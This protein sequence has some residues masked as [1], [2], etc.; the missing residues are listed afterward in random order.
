MELKQYVSMLW[1][2]NWLI[3]LATAVAI[4]SS[5]WATRGTPRLYRTSTTLMVGQFVQSTNPTA[6]D[7]QTSQQLAQTYAQMVRQQPV[8]QGTVDALGLRTGW[9]SLAGQVSAL[10]M[11]R[12]QLIQI[13]VVDTDPER[14]KILAN[15]VAHQLILQ[16]P[17]P[18][19]KEQ[20]QH[21][22]FVSRQLTDLQAKMEEAEGKVE[23]LEKRMELE[24]SARGLQDIQGQIGVLQQKMTTWQA[25]YA[26]LLSF[27]AGS[28]TNYLSVVEPATIAIPV[29]P[30][31]RTNVLLAGSIGFLLAA[32]AALLLEYLDDTIKAEEDVERVLRLP[33]LGAIPRIQKIR[34][35]SDHLVTMHHPRSHIAEAYRVLR[36][37]VQ[38]SSLS[39]PWS[40]LLVTSAGLVE[41]KTTTACNL[42]ITM[43]QA[44]KRVILTD[45]D[46]R[47]PVMHRFFGVPNQVGLTSLLLDETLPLEAALVETPV[48]GMK[49][50]PSGPL[51][52]NPAELLGSERMRE[53]L[54]QMKEW[55][56]LVIFDSPPLLAVADATV[57]GTLASGVILVAD[58]GRTR[59]DVIRRGKGTLDQVGLKVLGVVLNRVPRRRGYYDHYYSDSEGKG[60]RRR[61]R[62]SR[63]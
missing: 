8:L 52:P 32:G 59:S 43:A 1:K 45:T 57:L 25:N 62:G 16:S 7:F 29:S 33:T 36:T 30:R 27:F 47:R 53:R 19:E 23:E 50:M 24:T 10:P 51:P 18:A 35:P 12:T 38:F 17:T 4:G 15:E 60:R 3:V 14:A 41:G 56:D 49:L 34:E 6:Q 5:Y 9:R 26:S 31:S 11:A 2:W 58:A 39:N 13:S 40:R 61:R 44:G 28:R 46:L 37:N 22:E 55:A 21:R 63:A 42:G 48:E 20:D 54:E